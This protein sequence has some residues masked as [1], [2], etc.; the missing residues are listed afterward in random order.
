MT[1][2]RLFGKAS[3]A[4]LDEDLSFLRALDLQAE[5]YLP[6]H[7]LDSLDTQRIE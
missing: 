6:A 2:R 1:N 7:M 5:V 3:L 4:T